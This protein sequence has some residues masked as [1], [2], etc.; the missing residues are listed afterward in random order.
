MA[1]FHGQMSK[2]HLSKTLGQVLRRAFHEVGIP[3]CLDTEAQACPAL[4]KKGKKSSVARMGQNSGKNR[5]MGN[6]VREPGWMF[7]GVTE[8]M[9]I[10]PKGLL[11]SSSFLFLTL[12]L[13][14]TFYKALGQ[15]HYCRIF[16]VLLTML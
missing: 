7:P 14:V 5:V 6:E 4:S 8:L 10:P 2:E 9:F 16:S 11:T 13:A 12:F 15:A 1:T 3:Q